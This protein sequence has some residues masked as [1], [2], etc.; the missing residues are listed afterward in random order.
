[1]SE[2]NDLTMLVG[3]LLILVVF[4]VGA[5]TAQEIPEYDRG[6][7]THWVDDDRDGQNTRQEVLIAFSLSPVEFTSDTQRTVAAGEWYGRYT[8]ET[9]TTSRHVDVDHIVPLAWA[10]ENGA[11]AW[12]AS[13][14]RAF[15]NDPRNLLP[16]S[17]SANRS[18]G[19]KGPLEWM[20]ALESYHCEYLLR[21]KDVL[22]AYDLPVRVNLI[23]MAFR[24][25]NGG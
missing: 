22:Q 19:A 16:V 14:R 15:A 11:W 12:T 7:F 6:E 1:M 8:G 18:K 10:W 3:V 9:F 5:A 24:V 2:R 13:L 23:H 17:A 20:P 21:W 25:C 4:V